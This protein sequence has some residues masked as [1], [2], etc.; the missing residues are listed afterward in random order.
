[1][2]FIFGPWAPMGMLPVRGHSWN[3]FFWI[4]PKFDEQNIH[5]RY[6]YTSPFLTGVV[7]MER[8]HSQLS[9][10]AI[11][12]KNGDGQ[13]R[14]RRRFWS[15]FHSYVK[16]SRHA[17]RK[18]AEACFCGLGPSQTPSK[19]DDL[20]HPHHAVFMGIERIDSAE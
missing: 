15:G 2:N 20:I 16:S 11:L 10:G 14:Q 19:P 1:M 8:G 5:F 4:G 12:I 13:R 7:L 3:L 9:I 6:T 18:R 17:L